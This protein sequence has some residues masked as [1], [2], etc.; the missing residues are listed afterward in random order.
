MYG[1]L[2]ILLSSASSEDE[3]SLAT[4]LQSKRKC[5]CGRSIFA[6]FDV[7]A[8]GMDAKARFNKFFIL[9]QHE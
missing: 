9:H 8:V 1:F 6:F 4:A 5:C 7:E 2:S 3:E